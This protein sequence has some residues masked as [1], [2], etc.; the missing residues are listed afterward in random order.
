MSP[1][2][3]KL[4]RRHCSLALVVLVANLCTVALSVAQQFEISSLN[5]RITQLR[6]EG[7]L[8]EAI[9]LAQR[10]L[11]INEF[12]F[13]P[14]NPRIVP[15]LDNLAALY[16]YL[17]RHGDAEFLYKRALAIREARLVPELDIAQSLQNLAEVYA[18]QGRVAE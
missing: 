12:T 16:K 14:S 1:R 4:V 18:S 17:G 8:S 13:G 10:V 3:M 2:W 6:S 15:A 9:P 11:E 5:A 7:K